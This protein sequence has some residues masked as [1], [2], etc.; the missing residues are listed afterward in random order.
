MQAFH[1]IFYN[2]GNEPIHTSEYYGVG[3]VTEFRSCT[4]AGSCIKRNDFNCLKDFGNVS[5]S[6][7]INFSTWT[8]SLILNV[9]QGLS[10]GLHAV[11]FT[12]NHDNQRG[13]GNGGDVLTYK[14]D[15]ETKMKKLL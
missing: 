4:W 15:I 10:D 2:Q 7:W 11:V 9:F 13:H 5:W 3:K 8:W 1:S 14:V 12:D 6:I